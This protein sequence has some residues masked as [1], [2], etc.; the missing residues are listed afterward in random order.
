MNSS[1][2]GIRSTRL[3]LIDHRM[4]EK[5][6][7]RENNNAFT[8]STARLQQT[9]LQRVRDR[10]LIIAFLFFFCFFLEFFSLSLSV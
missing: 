9:E 4:I 3:D 7:D 10:T 6:N 5:E 2:D 1:S 8:V